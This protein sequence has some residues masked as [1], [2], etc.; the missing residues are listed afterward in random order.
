MSQTIDKR[1]IQ[2]EYA[3][4]SILAAMAASSLAGLGN[5]VAP[6]HRQPYGGQSSGNRTFT[7]GYKHT[8]EYRR[9]KRQLARAARKRNRPNRRV[10]I[11]ALDRQH[12]RRPG[13]LRS[14]RIYRG[15]GIN[16]RSVHASTCNA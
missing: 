10:S 12:R 5:L 9:R 1:R 11:S 13:Q 15:L 14:R 3:Y 4:A 2:A 6:A 8:A 16:Y 7:P